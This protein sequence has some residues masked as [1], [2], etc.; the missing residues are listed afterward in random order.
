MIM[1]V[2]LVC[3]S[4]TQRYSDGGPGEIRSVRSNP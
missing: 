3:A 2:R 1:A 4:M